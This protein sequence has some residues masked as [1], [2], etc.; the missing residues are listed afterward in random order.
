MHGEYKFKK[1][2]LVCFERCAGISGDVEVN[3]TGNFFREN[4][5]K[6]LK[7]IATQYEAKETFNRLSG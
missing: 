4:E 5:A 3:L 7:T 2:A 6:I 1:N